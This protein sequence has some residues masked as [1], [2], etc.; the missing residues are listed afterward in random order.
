M[1][2]L[3]YLRELP[4]RATQLGVAGITIW[5]IMA[6]IRGTPYITVYFTMK[7]WP[8]ITQDKTLDDD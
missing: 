6:S 2:D 3:Q 7:N 4:S 5:S 1:P 8:C